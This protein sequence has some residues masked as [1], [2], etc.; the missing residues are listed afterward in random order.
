MDPVEPPHRFCFFCG[1][2]VERLI[3]FFVAFG[4][5][6][7]VSVAFELVLWALGLPTRFVR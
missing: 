4:M 3:A 7:T 6:L 2:W 5:C 1:P